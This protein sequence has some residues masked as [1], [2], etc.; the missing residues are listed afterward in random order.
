MPL[1][2]DISKV[3]DRTAYCYDISKVKDRTTYCYDAEMNIHP[4]TKALI[5]MTEFIGIPRITEENHYEFFQRCRVYERLNGVR[6]WQQDPT[7]PDKQAERWISLQ[8]IR[9]HIGLRTNV[10]S[11]SDAKFKAEAWKDL[12][13]EILTDQRT[14]ITL[15]AEICTDQRTEATLCSASKPAAETPVDQ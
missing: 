11:L 3:K 1:D 12:M 2:W 7:D 5:Y 4:L 10:R 15:L 9:S 6:L 14:E 8:D 13:A